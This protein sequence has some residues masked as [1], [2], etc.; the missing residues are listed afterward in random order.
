M[1][2]FEV[3]DHFRQWWDEDW[4]WEGLANKPWKG[5]DED[6]TIQDYWLKEKQKDRLVD[7]AGRTWTRFHLPLHDLDGNLSDKASWSHEDFRD[8]SMAINRRLREKANE[9]RPLSRE[10]HLTMETNVPFNG[11]AFPASFDFQRLGI[12]CLQ[13]FCPLDSRTTQTLPLPIFHTKQ[14][15][16]MLRSAETQTSKM[17]NFKILPILMI[18]CSVHLQIFRLLIFSQ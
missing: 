4:S 17:P 14:N 16:E 10:E 3:D 7:F 18:L 2:N 15:L 1:T 8:F 6:S 13:I 12:P 11:L 5:G 9:L